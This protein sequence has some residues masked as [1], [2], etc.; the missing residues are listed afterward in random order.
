MD[1]SMYT[2]NLHAQCTIDTEDG[3]V[4]LTSKWLLKN[5]KVYLHHHLQSNRRYGTVVYPKNGD[6]LM[7]LSWALGRS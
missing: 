6:L 2:D 5:V 7:C 4:T 3:S 1:D